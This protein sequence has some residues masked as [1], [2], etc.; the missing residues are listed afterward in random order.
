MSTGFS[1]LF[2]D[3]QIFNVK[4]LQGAFD[5]MKNS[6]AEQVL[7]GLVEKEYI[8]KVD[9]D[10]KKQILTVIKENIDKGFDY[11][12]SNEGKKNNKANK[13]LQTSYILFCNEKREEVAQQNADKKPKEITAI[14]G[15]MWKS[16]SDEEKQPYVDTYNKN[17]AASGSEKEKKEKAEK[18]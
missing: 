18:K 15:A 4:Y 14:L 11:I 1:K 13:K 8:F 3:K 17:K 9:E 7:N 5:N 10:A 16:L 6:I 12:T 2:S